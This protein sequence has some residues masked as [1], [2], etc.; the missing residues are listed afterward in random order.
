MNKS[1]ALDKLFE[2]NKVEGFNPMELAVEYTDLID[3]TSSKRLPV[4]A[5][6]GWFRLC[7]PEGRISVQVSAEGGGYTAKARIYPD[8]KDPVEC[9][10]SEATATKY[11]IIGKP[12][13]SVK[14]WAQTAAIGIALR[15]AGFGLQFD[16][17]GE[18]FEPAAETEPDANT[19]KGDVKDISQDSAEASTVTAEIFQS[20]GESVSVEAEPEELTLEH[21]FEMP[22]PVLKYQGKSLKDVLVLEPNVIQWIAEKYTKDEKIK[23]AAALICEASRPSA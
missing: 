17:A 12:E 23:A 19:D 6:M 9:F 22:C 21:A 3:G 8:R 14:E 10:L 5:Q 16:M 4:R 11:P 1:A 20:A 7:Y 2:I 13:I 15:N 18:S